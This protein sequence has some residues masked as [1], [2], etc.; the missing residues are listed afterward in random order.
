MAML[1]DQFPG[2]EIALG[3]QLKHIASRAL[4]N[5]ST[6]GYANADSSW[7]AHLESTIEAARFR[8]LEDLY[9]THKTGKRSDTAPAPTRWLKPSTTFNTQPNL[10]VATQPSNEP[11]SVRL[12]SPSASASKPRPKPSTANMSRP[13]PGGRMEE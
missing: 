12:E 8:R 1:T 7:A 11:S 4:A 10:E 6:Q 9:Q 2:G 5:L 3:I 13:L